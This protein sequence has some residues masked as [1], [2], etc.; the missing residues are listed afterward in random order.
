MTRALLPA[1]KKRK[2]KKA[3]IINLSSSA[4][5][6]PEPYVAVYSATKV[7]DRYFSESLRFELNQSSSQIEVLTVLPMFVSTSMTFNIK[8]SWAT[9]VTSSE[10]YVNTLFKAMSN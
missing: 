10:Q 9:G 4:S 7:F 6:F 5:F 1:L 3:Q 8:P 2:D